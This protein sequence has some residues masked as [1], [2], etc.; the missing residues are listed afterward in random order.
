M[1][2]G[3]ATA[4]DSRRGPG[5]PAR[6]RTRERC[7]ATRPVG[8]VSAPIGLASIVLLN[9]DKHLAGRC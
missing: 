3:A 9:V 5:I 6:Q 4:A 2:S 1:T 8:F 7:G